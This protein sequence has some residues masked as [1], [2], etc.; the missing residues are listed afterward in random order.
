M[1][2]PALLEPAWLNSEFAPTLCRTILHTAMSLV[3]TD[4]TNTIHYLN[5]MNQESLLDQE[6]S[7]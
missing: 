5:Q 7:N 3:P 1:I 2:V 4:P 6:P